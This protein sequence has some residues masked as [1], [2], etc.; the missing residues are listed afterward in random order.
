[1]GPFAWRPPFPEALRRE[2]TVNPTRAIGLDCLSGLHPR[3]ASKC[4]ESRLR[5]YREAG[6]QRSPFD[7]STRAREGAFSRLVN[8]TQVR[9]RHGKDR[10]PKVQTLLHPP[11][12]HFVSAARDT[13]TVRLF[14]RLGVRRP[15]EQSQ[16][17]QA[18][19]GRD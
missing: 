4:T 19:P 10:L 8:L 3:L 5:G 17:P 2:E 11:S 6:L 18:V 15:C 7:R 16:P 14:P 13:E 1:M 9:H 12:Q